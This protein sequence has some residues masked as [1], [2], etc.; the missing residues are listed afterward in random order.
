MGSQRS[1]KKRLKSVLK[2]NFYEYTNLVEAVVFEVERLAARHN[3]IVRKNKNKI[4]YAQLTAIF[5]IF[6]V[7]FLPLSLLQ[8]AYSNDAAY[9][10]KCFYAS[11]AAAGIYYSKYFFL[12][13]KRF[14]ADYLEKYKT[15]QYAYTAGIQHC[16][17]VINSFFHKT[18]E[19]ENIFQGFSAE[20]MKILETGMLDLELDLL[21]FE[22]IVYKNQKCNEATLLI[23]DDYYLRGRD[24]AEQYL[25]NYLCERTFLKA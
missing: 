24:I 20:D 14:K 13:I 16:Q 2:H 15:Y 6:V 23:E 25:Q 8:L 3:E 19:I 4:L 10:E 7:V 11:W 17:K 22:E 18:G 1:T 21:L 12:R 5:G 9:L